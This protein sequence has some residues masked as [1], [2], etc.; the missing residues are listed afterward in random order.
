MKSRL[1][2]N[3]ERMIF[4]HIIQDARRR[5]N[6]SEEDLATRA[7]VSETCIRLCEF[8]DQYPSIDESLRIVRALSI[9]AHDLLPTRSRVLRKLQRQFQKQHGYADS[10]PWIE[11]MFHALGERAVS[12]MIRNIVCSDSAERSIWKN[13]PGE[14][15]RGAAATL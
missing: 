11:T 8:G 12:G 5:N 3:L 10:S 4:G 14:D 13:S 1:Q 6:L 7:K 2:Q 9:P 15:H